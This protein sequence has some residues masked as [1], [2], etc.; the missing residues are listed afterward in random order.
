MKWFK[1][2]YYYEGKN[3]RFKTF[4]TA[5]ATMKSRYISPI[6]IETGCQ[7]QKDDLGAGM[8]TSIFAEYIHRYGG[9]LLIIDNVQRHLNIA[10]EC[11]REWLS[12]K[13]FFYN[14]D[15]VSYL[16]QYEGKCSLLYLD[17]YDYPI[18]QMWDKYDGRVDLPKAMKIV[19]SK[20]QKELM[21][22][23]GDIIIPCQQHCLNE[24]KAVESNLDEDSIILVDDNNFPG[25]GKPGLLKPYLESK[26]WKS[27]LEGQQTLWVR[28]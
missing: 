25:G 13:V 14:S 15:S 28:K 10:K 19:E 26:D 11:I 6:I 12:S 18:G 4:E 27:L 1:D 5:L 17:S 2:K 23:F 16:R 7:R 8:S 22:E 21:S 3:E 24:F 9:T 20:S